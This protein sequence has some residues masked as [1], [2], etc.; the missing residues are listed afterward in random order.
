MVAASAMLL[1]FGISILI[2]GQPQTFAYSAALLVTFLG[3][4]LVLLRDNQYPAKIFIGDTFCYYAGAVL[5]LSAV[6]G[7][8]NV[9]QDKFQWSV[10]GFSCLNCSTSSIPPPNSS[11]ST[12]ALAT[13]WPTTTSR[14]TSWR[15]SRPT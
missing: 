15:P 10:T 1:Y 9:I 12:T 6:F 3:G 8:N 5:A 13:V 7:T 14:P 2:K 11:V 4:A